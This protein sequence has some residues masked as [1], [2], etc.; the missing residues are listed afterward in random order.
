M[1]SFF[2][3]FIGVPAIEIFLMIKI[4]GKIG[5][6]NTIFLI[7]FTAVLGL[8]FAKMEGLKTMR[9]GAINLYKNQIPIYEIVSGASIAIA[10]ILLIIPGFFTDI[11]GFLILIPITRKIFIKFLIKK[12]N[13]STKKGDSNVLDGEIIKDK[14]DEL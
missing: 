5:A 6:L 12:N 14:K 1:N 4:G 11:L 8:Y 3:L 13:N 7:F 10:A 2:L 9:S